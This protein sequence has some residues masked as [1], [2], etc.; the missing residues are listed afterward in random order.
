MATFI[1]LLGFLRPY[2]GGVITS[3]LLAAAAMVMTVAIPALTGRAIDQIRDGDGSE[4]N[5]LGILIGAA[6][7]GRLVL[8]V[9]R[10]LIA[11]R[12]SLGVELDLRERMYAHL[13]SLE[14]SFFDRQQ[15]GQL[16]SRATVDLQSVRF[17]LGYGLVFMMQSALTILLAAVAMVIVDPTLAAVSLIPVPIVIFV[18]ARYGRRG[19]PSPRSAR[20][21]AARRRRP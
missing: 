19:R 2:R 14:L 18:A 6:G 1:R 21:G 20:A 9:G 7:V 10:R 15:T 13:L 17:F 3:G 5:R 16:M 4:L 11:G 12:V 8:T